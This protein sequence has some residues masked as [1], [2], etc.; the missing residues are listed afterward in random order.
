MVHFGGRCNKEQM[1]YAIGVLL[2]RSGGA[3]TT[4]MGSC[5]E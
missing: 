1:K 4:L 5:F 2:F 3:G